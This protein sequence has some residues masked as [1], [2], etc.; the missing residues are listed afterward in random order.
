[1]KLLFTFSFLYLSF[2]IHAQ[3]DC[4]NVAAEATGVTCLGSDDGFIDITVTEGTPPYSFLWNTG[5]TTE[6]LND[7]PAG[8]YAVEVTDSTGCVTYFPSYF[9]LDFLGAIPDGVGVSYQFPLLVDQFEADQVLDSTDVLEICIIIEHSWM[10]DLEI[11]V[12]CPDGISI[13]LHDH[14]GN[15][16]GEN[17][18]GIPIDADNPPSP[19]E[20]WQYCWTANSING[21]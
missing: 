14:P 11:S 16:G 8:N 20:G 3:T 10:R 1:M 5:A 21:T 6:D 15:F 7:V 2:Y 17:Y 13:I 18:L 4:V 9:L 12:Q 19:G